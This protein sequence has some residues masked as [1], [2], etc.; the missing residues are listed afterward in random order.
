ML[1]SFPAAQPCVA[2]TKSI[3]AGALLA[4]IV[5]VV[6][7]APPSLVTSIWPVVEAAADAHP[8]VASTNQIPLMLVTPA[9]KDCDVQVTPPSGVMRITPWFPALTV[10]TAHPFVELM[11]CTP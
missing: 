5:C 7:V 11:K 8:C 2:S 1:L 4:G 10:P 6:Q 9:G 3:P